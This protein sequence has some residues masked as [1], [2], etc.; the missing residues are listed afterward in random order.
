MTVIR[1]TAKGKRTKICK[2]LSDIS[3]QLLATCNVEGAALTNSNFTIL[4]PPSAFRNP[5][6]AI[7]NL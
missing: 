7:R 5:H 1:A 2:Q 3:Y 4:I 6:S